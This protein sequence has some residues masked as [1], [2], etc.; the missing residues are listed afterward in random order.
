MAISLR[1]PCCCG[2]EKAAHEHYRRGTDCSGCD[3]QRFRG[4][5]VVTLSLGPVPVVTARAVAPDEV[6][7]PESPYVRPT[8]TAGLP[9]IRVG[10]Q[11]TAAPAPVVR[12]RTE[13]EPRLPE[14]SP[15]A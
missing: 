6:P 11:G 8:H 7:Y 4:R 15:S 10:G 5:L 1:R 9:A 12:P 14:Q 3:C 13:A 2:H